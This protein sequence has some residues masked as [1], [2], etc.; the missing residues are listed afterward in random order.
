MDDTVEQRIGS[1]QQPLEMRHRQQRDGHGWL[2]TT[3]LPVQAG[4]PA[5]ARGDTGNEPVWAA[6]VASGP[7]RMRIETTERSSK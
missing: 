1:C 5:A 7:K 2:T 6:P 4:G 3:G